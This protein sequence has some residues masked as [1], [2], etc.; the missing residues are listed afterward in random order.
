M[1]PAPPGS[2]DGRRPWV[3]HPLG[4]GT[5]PL[6]TLRGPELTSAGHRRRR[7]RERCPTDP[8]TRSGAGVDPVHHLGGGTGRREGG[9]H[10][11][12]DPTFAPT[13]SASPGKDPGPARTSTRH[14]SVG[15]SDLLGACRTGPSL[16]CPSSRSIRWHPTR[17]RHGGMPPTPCPRWHGR[18]PAGSTRTSPCMSPPRSTNGENSPTRGRSPRPRRATRRSW[19]GWPPAARSSSSVSRAR[20]PRT[21][22]APGIP[23]RRRPRRR[24]GPSRPPASLARLCGSSPIDA[25]SGNHLRHRLN[26]RGDRRAN[27][28]LGH[29]VLTS[30]GSDQ[31]TRPCSD[32]R[33]KG[34]MD[35]PRRKPSGAS[36]A[37]SHG[38]PATTYRSKRSRLAAH[39]SIV[40]SGAL[41]T[42]GA[43]FDDSR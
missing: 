41:P 15:R 35:S 28:A 21:P 40:Q 20:A 24:G 22:S 6:G 25:G 8:A 34:R 4:P 11:R 13:P 29:I 39:W 18:S 23:V 38:R 16:P 14:R 17:I 10:A 7:G 43:T 36:I 12:S 37:T 32:R 42:S 2:A 27:A 5:W 33:R 26:R 19:A 3:R 31:G 30:T 1:A 9:A